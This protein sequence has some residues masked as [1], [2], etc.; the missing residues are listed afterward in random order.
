MKVS[1][2]GYKLNKQKC[3]LASRSEKCHKITVKEKKASEKSFPGKLAAEVGI[4][5]TIDAIPENSVGAGT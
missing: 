4:P 3:N 2:L 1:F 5:M